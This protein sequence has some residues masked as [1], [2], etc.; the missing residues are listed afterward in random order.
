[1]LD[2]QET[3]AV[4]D[5]EIALAFFGEVLA[6]NDSAGRYGANCF[7]QELVHFEFTVAVS[8]D[9]VGF[10]TRRASGV[11]VAPVIEVSAVWIGWIFGVVAKAEGTWVETV[12][13][14]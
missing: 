13:G 2:S 8:T 5:D 7:I 10:T 14:G 6:G 12:D 9:L 3:D 1:M 11:V 4:E